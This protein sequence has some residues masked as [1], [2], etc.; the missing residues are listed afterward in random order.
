[1]EIK[2]LVNH[3]FSSVSNLKELTGGLASQTYYFEADENR[4]VF[5]VGKGM[6]AYEKEKW[7]YKTLRNIL[8]VRNVL[9]VQKMD[10]EMSFSIS[11]FIE[12]KKL[13]DLNG[14]ELL[15]IVPAVIKTLDVLESIEISNQECFGYFDK[16]GQ[17]AYPT[18]LDFIEA[19]YN[20]N[21]Y[22]WSALDKNGLDS[23]VVKSAMRELEAHISSVS[24]SKVN[25]VHGDLGSFNLLAKDG[26]ITGIIDWSL[27]LYGDH[28]YDKANILFWNEDKLQPLVQQITN[29]Y[30]T[31]QDIKEKIYCYMLRIGLEEL[32]NTVILGETGY[33]IEWVANR[34]QKIIDEFL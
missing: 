25:I 34:L 2:A 5:Q 7:I 3:H 31:S 14:Q 12:G 32:H 22:D 13:F 20:E 28:L 19:V 8:P 27:S 18:W 1:M 10:N 16:T 11:T 17:A 24:L 26:Q 30:I 9:D 21:I 4:Y 6:E 23:E 33:D 29:K 15:D